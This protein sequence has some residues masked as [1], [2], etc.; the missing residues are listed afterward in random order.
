[1]AESTGTSAPKTRG[2][3]AK[4]AARK[5]PATKK[6]NA[7]NEPVVAA[8]SPAA[9][10]TQERKTAATPVKTVRKRAAATTVSAEE[11][12]R[13]IAEAAYLRAELRN[14]VG[15]DPVSDWLEAEADVNARLAGPTH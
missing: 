5:A 9:R 3:T 4:P 10:K 6:A 11:R 1:M 13:M 7:K 15:G 8:T 14:F 2:K 12:Q